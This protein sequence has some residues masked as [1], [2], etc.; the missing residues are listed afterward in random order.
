[1]A[2]RVTCDRGP[3][4]A[5]T[6]SEW[7]SIAPTRSSRWRAPPVVRVEAGDQWRPGELDRSVASR[8]DA[9]VGLPEVANALVDSGKL[10]VG[11]VRGA[12][13]GD[14]DLVVGERLGQHALDRPPHETSTL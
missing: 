3:V 11:P 5:S 1:L 13:V 9:A 2:D 6:A 4:Q 8:G 10:L 12:V 14:D 7:A